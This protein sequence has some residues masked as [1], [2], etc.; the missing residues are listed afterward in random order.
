MHGL[1]IFFFIIYFGVS[2][3]LFSQSPVSTYAKSIRDCQLKKHLTFLASDSLKGR[4]T[5]SEGQ[6]IAAKYVAKQFADNGLKPIIKGL[7]DSLSYFQTYFLQRLKH[8]GGGY[9]YQAINPRT[10]GKID[11]V[12]TENVLGF[13]EGTD[14]KDEVIVISAHLDHIG[15]NSDGQINNGADDDGSGTVALIELSQA[16]ARAKKNGDGPRRS[17][18]FLNVTGEEKGLLGSKYFVE[19]PIFPLSKIVCNLNIDMIGRTDTEHEGKPD[20]IYLI[21]SDKLSSKLHEISEKANNEHTMLA[22][23]YTFNNPDDP[24]RFY[25]RSDHYNFAE[26]KIPVIFYF[27][28]VHADYHQPGDDIEKIQFDQMEKI[29]RLVFYTAWDLAN[30][31]DRIVVDSDKK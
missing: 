1:K 19:N 28:G 30:R 5:G 25:Y 3:A 10:K 31:E 16:F 22:L 4:D 24:N 27:R 29:T 6:K 23:D 18:L 9:S 20:Y 14:K 21:G 11:S 2:S 7:N 26:K 17:L 12:S 15:V 13:I 8:F